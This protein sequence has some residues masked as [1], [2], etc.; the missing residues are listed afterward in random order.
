[1][2]LLAVFTFEEAGPGF[3][4]TGLGGTVGL[5]EEALPRE[6][7]LPGSFGVTTFDAVVCAL[8]LAAVDTAVCV[9]FL[10]A[11]DTAVCVFEV[12]ALVTVLS[13]LSATTVL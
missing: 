13:V 2:N 11:L 9:L 7:C 6:V 12:L 10:T 4:G 5:G 1:V 8:V 3:G